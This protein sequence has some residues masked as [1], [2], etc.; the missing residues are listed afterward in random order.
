MSGA[1]FVD[2]VKIWLSLIELVV[3]VSSDMSVFIEGFVVIVFNFSNE[4]LFVSGEI[5]ICGFNLFIDD[6]IVLMRS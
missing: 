2:G 6:S 4:S 5:F 3:F 1:Q